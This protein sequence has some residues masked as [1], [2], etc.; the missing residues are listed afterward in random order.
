[1]KKLNVE[2]RD[3]K[4]WLEV[5]GK[6]PRDKRKPFYNRV[7]ALVAVPSRKRASVDL[8]KISMHTKEGDNV[9]VPGKVLGMGQ[10]NHSV[11]I[12]AISFS[13]SALKSLKAANCK[14]M[15]IKDMLGM[16]KP[17]ILV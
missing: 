3:I 15:S 4:E 14:I 1:M 5:V 17:H 7:Y 2:R 11:N 6:V 13:A 12:A 10:M 8:Y 9:I 16:S